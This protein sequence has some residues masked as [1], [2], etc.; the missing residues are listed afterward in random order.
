M[1]GYEHGGRWYLDTTPRT[2][3][4]LRAALAAMEGK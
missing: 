2:A 3:H 4:N 1:N